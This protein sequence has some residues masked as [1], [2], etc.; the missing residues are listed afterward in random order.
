[1]VDS[2]SSVPLRHPLEPF[3]PDR[4]VPLSRVRHQILDMNTRAGH[5]N[6]RL[7]RFQRPI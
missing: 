1:M 6:C 4:G 3:D 7:I 5:E 2:G